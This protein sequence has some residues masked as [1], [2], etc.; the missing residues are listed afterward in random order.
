MTGCVARRTG[1]GEDAFVVVVVVLGKGWV[2]D[3]NKKAGRSSAKL[4]ASPASGRAGWIVLFLV[5]MSL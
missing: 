5:S 2:V 3:L 1:G 4:A